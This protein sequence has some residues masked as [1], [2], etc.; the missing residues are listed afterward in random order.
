MSTKFTKRQHTV[1]SFYL[2]NFLAKGEST[3]WVYDKKGEDPRRQ[4]PKDSA[5]ITDFYTFETPDGEKENLEK[6]G[7]VN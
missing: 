7:N 5:V 4:S 3:L 1:P 2:R 6:G